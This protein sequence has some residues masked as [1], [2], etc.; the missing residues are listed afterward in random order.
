MKASVTTVLDVV[1]SLL[2]VA[3]CAVWAAALDVLPLVRGL[4]VAGGGLLLVSWFIDGAP[5]PR[6]WKRGG[7]R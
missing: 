2:L 5:L 1:G 3:A 7:R 4:A 6:V